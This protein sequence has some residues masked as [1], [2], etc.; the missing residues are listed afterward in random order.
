MLS[1]LVADKGFCRMIE[2][3][4]HRCYSRTI[5]LV[6]LPGAWEKV[7]RHLSV[8][9]V[10]LYVASSDTYVHVFSLDERPNLGETAARLVR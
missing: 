10:N 6:E 5:V 9:A 2:T 7:V 3:Q 1:L 8:V 4:H